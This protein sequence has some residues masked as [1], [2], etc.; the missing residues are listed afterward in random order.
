[1]RT[2][3]PR[4]NRTA[5]HKF[6][7]LGI[8]CSDTCFGLLKQVSETGNAQKRETCDRWSN[9]PHVPHHYLTPC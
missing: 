2:P 9:Y 6:L 8:S 3:P 7:I 5:G 4:D 1:M